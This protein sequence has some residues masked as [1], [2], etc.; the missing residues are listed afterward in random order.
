MGKFEMMLSVYIVRKN[1]IILKIILKIRKNI[2][3][4]P[5]MCGYV[6]VYN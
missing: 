3:P 5:H 1:S 4:N 2:Q 6:F